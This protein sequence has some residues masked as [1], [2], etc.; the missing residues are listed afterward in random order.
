MSLKQSQRT[1]NERTT[2]VYSA[3]LMD[4]SNPP[5]PIALA[6]IV[7]AKLTLIDVESGA[8][9]NSRNEVDI[10]N[11]GPCTIHA[12]TGAFVLV[13]SEEDNQIVGSKARGELEEHE[14]TF[15]IVYDTD[16]RLTHPLVIFVKQLVSITG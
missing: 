8:V 6:S 5:V 4:H 12:T 16:K 1:V 11:T 13:F 15:D 9:I 14:A 10:K 3:V 2:L 7:S